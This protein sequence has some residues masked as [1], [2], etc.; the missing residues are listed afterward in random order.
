MQE[1]HNTIMVKLMYEKDYAKTFHAEERPL[2]S[3]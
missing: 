2:V 3:V 1:V